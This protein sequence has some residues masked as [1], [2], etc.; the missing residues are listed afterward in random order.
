MTAP[1]AIHSTSETRPPTRASWRLTTSV[2][3]LARCEA[4]GLVDPR[5][6]VK[7]GP[8]HPL[9]FGSVYEPARVARRIACPALARR[10]VSWRRSAETQIRRLAQPTA[11]PGSPG[12]RA[13]GPRPCL[14]AVAGVVDVLA[15]DPI[16]RDLQ[17]HRATARVRSSHP[18][19]RPSRFRSGEREKARHQPAGAGSRLLRSS[20]SAVLLRVARVPALSR[21]Q[22]SS[23]ITTSSTGAAA[24]PG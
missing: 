11:S 6:V 24:S 7:V 12:V 16:R 21:S 5:V 18:H 4:H 15:G 19:R 13:T 2:S 10:E 8:R 1:S 3:H 22:K 17:A 14:A 23:S 20:I 9:S